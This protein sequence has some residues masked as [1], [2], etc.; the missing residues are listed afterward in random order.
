MEW[1]GAPYKWPE[2]NSFPLGEIFPLLFFRGSN[3]NPMYKTMV[4]GA[5]QLG[6]HFPS[7]KPTV[8]WKYAG[9]H[10]GSRIVFQP[11][12]FRCLV[13]CSFRGGRPWVTNLW[14]QQFQRCLSLL[15]RS[16]NPNARTDTSSRIKMIG[17]SSPGVHFGGE[18]CGF[19]LGEVALKRTENSKSFWC[20]TEISR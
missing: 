17:R 13:C 3:L 19:H 12:I 20:T 6:D 1:N 2:I 8:R 16:A 7:L 14:F 5:H 11:S 15:P 4:F 10:F 18:T 9:P